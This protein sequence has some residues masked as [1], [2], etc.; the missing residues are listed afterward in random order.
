MITYI[1][2]DFL[3]LQKKTV[4]YQNVRISRIVFFIQ[5]IFSSIIEFILPYTLT[6]LTHYTGGRSFT[7]LFSKFH[8]SGAGRAT[9]HIT[10]GIL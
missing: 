4:F 5:F 2:Y 7:P 10:V 3:Y 1:T 9:N 6:V 8:D